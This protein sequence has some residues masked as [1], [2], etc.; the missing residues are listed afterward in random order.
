MKPGNVLTQVNGQAASDVIAFLN[1]IALTS[2]GDEIKINLP[3]KGKSITLKVQV[4]KQMKLKKKTSSQIKH[5][6]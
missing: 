2:S 6:F 1:R 3:R 4:E 5:Y